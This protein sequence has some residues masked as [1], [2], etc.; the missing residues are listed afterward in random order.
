MARRKTEKILDRVERSESG[1]VDI[2]RVGRA[3]LY[4][5]KDI[6]TRLGIDS[7]TTT[8]RLTEAEPGY[9]RPEPSVNRRRFVTIYRTTKRRWKSYRIIFGCDAVYEV[10]DSIESALSFKPGETRHYQVETAL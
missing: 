7:A 4:V 10:C 2:G 6:A 9:A 8:I 3:G 1:Q 5:D